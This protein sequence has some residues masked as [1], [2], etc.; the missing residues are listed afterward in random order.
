MRRA[1]AVLLG[2]LIGLPLAFVASAYVGR[3]YPAW[4]API[5]AIL[6]ITLAGVAA[7]Y[8]LRGGR[9][10]LASPLHLLTILLALAF[11]LA[12]I[13][14]C[15]R[16]P[17]LFARSLFLPTRTVQ[18]YFGS[19]ALLALA[20][21]AWSVKKINTIADSPRWSTV[22]S[23]V[24]E[25]LPGIV[26]GGLFFLTYAALAQVFN[27]P[28]VDT[29][30][31]FLAA[32]NFAWLDRLASSGGTLTEMR[33]VHP[34][35]YLIFRPAV[36]LLSIVFNGDRTAATF[37]LVP[38]MGGLCVLLIWMFVKKWTG[39]ETYASLIACL[40][41]VSTAH[42]LFASI[43][44]TYIFSAAVLLLFFL[45]LLRERTSLFTLVAVGTLTFGITITNFIQTFIAFCV[46]RPKL[47]AI[48]WYGLLVSAAA[49][50]LTLL[51]AALYP[52]ALVFFLPSG[53]SVENEYAIPIFGQPAW[54][55]AGRAILLVRTIF[56]YSIVAPEPFILTEEVGGFFPRFNFFKITPGNFHYSGYDGAG[57]LLAALWM[58]LVCAAGLAFV[59]RLVRTRKTDLTLAFALCILFNFLLHMGYGYEPFLYSANW[60]Y[61]L[62]LFVALSLSELADRRWFQ[63]VLLLF[64]GLLIFNQWKFMQ[65]IFDSISPFLT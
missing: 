32:D 7:Q 41:G 37:L 59:W 61:A 31:N 17:N 16:Y 49:I 3:Y 2:W 12:V 56:L 11:V 39:S 5:I 43:I 9:H 45:L 57:Q 38:M 19:L 25:N 10:W 58:L 36:A 64:L 47:K 8:I 34:F 62:I 1:S 46:A 30:E 50:A 4:A 26:L 28:G 60:T 22:R 13:C 63:A 23:F 52:S 14:L 53:T 21:I 48:F 18:V 55:L 20:S 65:L 44:E 15:L 29:T 6:A 35:A 42:L 24:Q 51:H 54:R 33:A 27:R 40:L